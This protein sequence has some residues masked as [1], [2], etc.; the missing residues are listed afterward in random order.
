M[1][2]NEKIYSV[3]VDGQTVPTWQLFW[4][5]MMAQSCR[6]DRSNTIAW[7]A[8]A[9]GLIDFAALVLLIISGG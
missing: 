8:L 2:D 6:I 1:P 4:E 9:V 3:Q 5:Q 7:A